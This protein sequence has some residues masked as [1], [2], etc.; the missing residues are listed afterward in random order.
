MPVVPFEA[1]PAFQGGRAGCL[2]KLGVLGLGYYA[3]TSKG[4]L[5]ELTRHGRAMALTCKSFHEAVTPVLHDLRK[6]FARD[7]LRRAIDL[8]KLMGVNGPG[9]QRRRAMN[10]MKETIRA[11]HRKTRAPDPAACTVQKL[12]RVLSEHFASSPDIDDA[13]RAGY[14]EIVEE[15]DSREELLELCRTEAVGAPLTRVGPTHGAAMSALM[16]ALDQAAAAGILS[17]DA[18]I[19]E[20]QQMKEQ[21]TRN[22]MSILFTRNQMRQNFDD[23]ASKLSK[24]ETS[25]TDRKRCAEWHEDSDDY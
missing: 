3:D 13:D 5:T 4:A 20:S 10:E 18:G 9:Q 8:A 14:I 21:L 19:V 7:A 16:A 11:I 6:L 1:A 2:F 24:A 12:K 22:A 15:E 25:E 23:L 17:T